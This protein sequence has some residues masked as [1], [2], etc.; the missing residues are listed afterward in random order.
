MKCLT[1]FGILLLVSSLA[2]AADQTRSYE[3]VAVNPQSGETFV[4][5]KY[6]NPEGALLLLNDK[7]PAFKDS[8]RLIEGSDAQAQFEIELN[9]P[10]NLTYLV[11]S[12]KSW[13]VGGIRKVNG[14]WVKLAAEKGL[15]G[16]GYASALATLPDSRLSLIVI[17][18]NGGKAQVL[19]L[20]NSVLTGQYK[21]LESIPK[22]KVD[23][24]ANT[25]F[26]NEK[27]KQR[28]HDAAFGTGNGYGF[29]AGLASGVGLAYRHHFENKWGV[30]IA[31][32]G[33]GNPNHLFGDAGFEV[34]RTLHLAEKVRFYALAATSVFYSNNYQQDYST[35]TPQ[36]G[37]KT[38]PTQPCNPPLEWRRT[39]NLNFATGIGMEYHVT[40]NLG[41]S[42]DVPLSVQIDISN[43][44]QRKFQGIT[45]IPSASLIYYF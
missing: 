33:Y 35:C 32:I 11:Q 12:G 18:S 19:L 40:K 36:P 9:R 4:I 5:E 31:G 14:Q 41:I 39:G 25:I 27:A 37:S 20:E 17:P 44:S 21:I 34:I 15:K 29:A 2:Q 24:A 30:Q 1:V 3:D 7:D 45:W 23:T 26:L 38:D 10:D 28:K 6:Q 16:E 43:Q 8:I 42:F 22:E 13:M